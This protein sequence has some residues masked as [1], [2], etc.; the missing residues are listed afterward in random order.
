MSL[1]RSTPLSGVHGSMRR[2]QCWWRAD[3]RRGRIY[4]ADTGYKAQRPFCRLHIFFVCRQ[5]SSCQGC[6]ARRC[7][8][9]HPQSLQYRR[10]VSHPKAQYCGGIF[11][12]AFAVHRGQNMPKAVAGMPVIKALLPRCGGGKASQHQY[13]ASV[14]TERLKGVNNMR[15]THPPPKDKR[16]SQRTESSNHTPQA[17]LIIV[18]CIEVEPS[19][20]ASPCM[21]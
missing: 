13:S 16:S 18:P 1:S 8:C 3:K 17:G 20:R 14:R 11:R 5:N 15:H 6:R 12:H 7:V 21:P 4:Q 2:L 19:H 10:K 9:L